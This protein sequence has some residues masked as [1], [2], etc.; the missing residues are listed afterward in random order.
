VTIL[1]IKMRCIILGTLILFLSLAPVVHALGGNR[2]G[3]LYFYEREKENG[4]VFLMEAPP[5]YTLR[6]NAQGEVLVL[7]KNAETTSHVLDRTNKNAWP[8]HITREGE[9]DLKCVMKPSGEVREVRTTWLAHK[10]L[11][12]LQFFINKQSF[13]KDHSAVAIHPRLRDL[14]FG[15]KKH[16]TRTVLTLD[17]KPRWG[18]SFSPEN[19]FNLELAGGKAKM[20][21]RR[22][23]PIS[24]LRA[25][26]INALSNGLWVAFTP[27]GF[28]SNARLFWLDKGNR[29]VMDLFD[30][31]DMTAVNAFTL[32]QGF[33]KEGTKPLLAAKKI[34]TGKP[35]DRSAVSGE[36]ES[37]L[38]G[39]EQETFPISSI[40]IPHPEKAVTENPQLKSAIGEG[41]FVRR[42]IDLPG[43]PAVAVEPA[44]VKKPQEVRTVE[45]K[46]HIVNDQI[47]RQLLALPLK[48]E[49]GQKLDPEEALAYGKIWKAKERKRFGD[50]STLIDQFLARFPLSVMSKK[51]MYLKGDL[52]FSRLKGGEK[53]LLSEVIEAYRKAISRSKESDMVINGYMRMAEADSL[54]GNDIAAISFLNLAI[55]SC[56]GCPSGAKPYLERGR[57]LMK[58]GSPEKAVLDFKE[59]LAHYPNSRWVIS[60]LFGIAQYLHKEGLYQNAEARLEQIAGLDHDFWLKNPDFLSL[61][62]QNFLY[63]K[64]YE[65]ARDLFFKALNLGSRSEGKDLLLTHIGDT[66]LYQFRPKEAEKMYRQAVKDFPGSEGA[67]IAE[68]RLAEMYFDVKALKKVRNQNQGGLTEEVTDL[69]IANAYYNGGRYKMAMDSLKELAS[70]PPQDTVTAAAREMFRQAA[71]KRMEQLFKDHQFSEVVAVFKADQLLLKDRIDPDIQLLVPTSLQELKKYGDSV[72]AY[73][74]LNPLDVSLKMKGRY[75]LGLARCYVKTGDSAAAVKLMEDGRKEKLSEKDRQRV[76]HFLADLYKAEKEYG[77]AYALFAELMRSKIDLSSKEM[78]QVYLALGEI[79]NKLGKYHNAK[80]YLYRSIALSERERD[81]QDL[82]FL[83]LGSL[84]NSFL[85]EGKYGE[86]L[87]HYQKAFDMGSGVTLPEYWDFKLGQAEALMATGESDASGSLLSAV[88]EAHGPGPRYWAL[89][90]RLAKGYLRAGKVEKAEVQLREIS[91]EGTPV[92]QSDAQLL[93]GSLALQKNL[94]KL[95]IWP[96]IEAQRVQHARQ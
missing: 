82:Y 39:K 50:A 15:V 32:P 34:P 88:Y 72:V 48:A 17:A 37:G 46:P 14:R 49:G 93:L 56:K 68:L 29:L 44:R 54:T 9:K 52:L 79:L 84:G 58:T 5:A 70:K 80:E 83:G 91:E 59:V 23:G 60:A 61:R 74:A 2:V 63:L 30:E 41:P 35:E 42:P 27:E 53:D 16:Y 24:R 26:K 10:K 21:R 12:F 81:S 22:F 8:L 28:K 20:K 73:E 3:D 89:K 38:K 67:G 75:Y 45:N 43:K 36:K 33:G 85:G 96:E 19:G 18:F 4:I 13:V 1:K 7:L 90:Y 62:A 47:G 71:E 66:Y 64:D 77:K 31:P 65:R 11:F 57:L 55:K 40:K 69:K 51:L 87:S 78:A 95:S 76:T 94:K 25:V 92:L 6:A 86:A